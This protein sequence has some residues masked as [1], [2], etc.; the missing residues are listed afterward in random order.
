MFRKRLPIA[1][2]AIAGLTLGGFA[3]EAAAG[4]RVLSGNVVTNK[5]IVQYN[6][7]TLRNAQGHRIPGRAL[8]RTPGQMYCYHTAGGSQRCT[9]IN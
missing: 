4:G 7:P 3:G 8:G 1:A 6:G 5:P 2:I 9:R